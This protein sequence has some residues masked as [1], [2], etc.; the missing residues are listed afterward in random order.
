MY[1]YFLEKQHQTALLVLFTK[2]KSFSVGTHCIWDSSNVSS[3]K[4]TN[5][6]TVVLSRVR[7]VN[8]ISQIK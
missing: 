6:S 8:I 7:F 4:F 1:K 5:K 3:N 2:Y